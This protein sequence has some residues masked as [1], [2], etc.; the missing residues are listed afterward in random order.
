MATSTSKPK[1]DY[2]LKSTKSLMAGAPIIYA[3]IIKVPPPE[4]RENPSSLNTL[5]LVAI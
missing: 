3:L 5:E 2:D 1:W 4:G